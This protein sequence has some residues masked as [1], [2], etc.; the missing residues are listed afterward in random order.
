ME[1]NPAPTT[2]DASDTSQCIQ[3]HCSFNTPIQIQDLEISDL[4]LINDE[5]IESYLDLIDYGSQTDSIKTNLVILTNQRII[6]TNQPTMDCNFNSAWIKEVDSIDIV[7]DRNI[8]L[9]ISW[10][11]LS[12]IVA[13]LLLQAWNNVIAAAITS[14]AMVVIGIYMIIDRIFLANTYK[15]TIKSNTEKFLIKL[16]SIEAYEK[17]LSLVNRLFELKDSKLKDSIS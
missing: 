14:T 17:M 13:I 5:H 16:T 7:S 15:V 4:E 1:E 12:F 9:G 6:H 2:H 10:G 8:I 11:I 3:K